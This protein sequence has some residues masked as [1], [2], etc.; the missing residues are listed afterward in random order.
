MFNFRI[1]VLLLLGGMLVA[2]GGSAVISSNHAASSDALAA[3]GKRG[4]NDALRDLF[5]PAQGTKRPILFEAKT[6]GDRRS[7]YTAVG[8][9]WLYTDPDESW[10]RV[11]VLPSNTAENLKA[12]LEARGIRVLLYRWRTSDPKFIG[13]E[14]LLRALHSA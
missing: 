3:L 1:V 2:C 5:I 13:L 4:F 12:T 9:L 14:E 10:H 7:I 6:R 8:Q 11:A